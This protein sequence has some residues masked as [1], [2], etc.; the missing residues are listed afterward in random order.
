MIAERRLPAN[1]DWLTPRWMWPGLAGALVAG[2]VYLHVQGR[3]WWC[4]CGEL[5]LWSDDVH[6]PHNSQH[7]FDPYAFT[8]VL[9]GL[10]FYGAAAWMLPRWTFPQRLCVATLVEIGWELLENTQFI[11]ERYRATNI[12]QGYE[13]DSIANVG[14]DVLAAV[15]GAFFARRFGA[16]ASIILFLVVELVLL[17]RIRDGLVL[18][19]IMLIYPTDALNAWQTAN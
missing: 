19:I 9:H 11:I 7:L 6:S 5:W 8:H 16:R 1:G 15:A 18:N 14:G 13:G 2:A 4:A 17:A 10:I 3:P 12:A